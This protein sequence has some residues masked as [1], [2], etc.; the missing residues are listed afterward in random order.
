MT[1]THYRFFV[2]LGFLE[3]SL[4]RFQVSILRKM[5]DCPRDYQL[6]YFD[7]FNPMQKLAAIDGRIDPRM[8]PRSR[9][10]NR[11]ASA[12]DESNEQSRSRSVVWML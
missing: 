3:F 11:R 4:A 2:F 1:G 5:P 6:L 7:Y 8:I 12:L 10:D 9:L